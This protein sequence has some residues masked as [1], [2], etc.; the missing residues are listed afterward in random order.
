MELEG[1][2]EA[3]LG[4][5]VSLAFI[6]RGH[7]NT[8][9]GGMSLLPACEHP[10]GPQPCLL[11][12]FPSLLVP[13]VALWHQST[14][15]ESLTHSETVGARAT[16]TLTYRK[17]RCCCSVAESCLTLC[18]PMGCSL[19]G[20]SVHA[21]LQARILEWG[22]M[23]FSRGSSPPRDQTCI[24]SIDRGILSHLQHLRVTFC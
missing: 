11:L 4:G 17:K 3:V 8:S 22:A 15:I 16:P 7:R 20:T 2:A 13:S 9:R 23:P 21:I 24:S 10:A 14:Y 18:R 19:S 6:S 5:A 1:P 12:L